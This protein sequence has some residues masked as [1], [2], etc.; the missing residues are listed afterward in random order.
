MSDTEVRLILLP[1]G[2]DSISV[3]F[4]VNSSEIE[5]EAAIV[6][7]A[8]V[9]PAIVEP[10]IAEHLTQ[11]DELLISS[12]CRE[13][14]EDVCEN[15]VELC[16]STLPGDIGAVEV[17]ITPLVD[18]LLDHAS[19]KADSRK[20]YTKSEF[21]LIGEDKALKAFPPA[22]D[23]SYPGFREFDLRVT[24]MERAATSDI[25]R[26][27]GLPDDD[28]PIQSL[29][30]MW[31]TNN[32]AGF[33]PGA[34]Q[35]A[36]Q[37][38][39]QLG[40]LPTRPP[41]GFPPQQN[42]PIRSRL[43]EDGN[44][45]ETNTPRDRRFGAPKLTDMA[46]GARGGAWAASSPPDKDG[47][48]GFLGRSPPDRLRDRDGQARVAAGP[49]VEH[50]MVQRG[51]D[52]VDARG[53]MDR[54]HGDRWGNDPKKPGDNWRQAIQDDR[55]REDRGGDRGDRGDRAPVKERWSV[56]RDKDAVEEVGG[57][58]G[59]R[60]AWEM[61]RQDNARHDNARQDNARQDNARQDRDIANGHGMRMDAHQDD[62]YGGDKGHSELRVHIPHTI[63]IPH[64]ITQM[65]TS[66][67]CHQQTV[68]IPHADGHGMRVDA[69]RDDG[70]DKRQGG[71]GGQGGRRDA[72]Q[73]MTAAEMETERLKMREEMAAAKA[74]QP[75]NSTT[76]IFGH[77]E[78]NLDDLIDHEFEAK[79]AHQRQTGPPPGMIPPVQG[80]KMSFQALAQAAASGHPGAMVFASDAAP[81]R[82]ALSNPTRCRIAN[83]TCVL[84]PVTARPLRRVV[85]VDAP[86]GDA[87]NMIALR[88]HLVLIPRH[89]S[90]PTLTAPSYPSRGT[91]L[92][93]GYTM[94]SRLIGVR[95]ESLDPEYPRGD[96]Y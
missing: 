43:I 2:E 55:N 41:P 1:V 60:R 86:L 63:T 58:D 64:A 95:S 47:G 25:L 77:E 44:M 82:E 67:T 88:P 19:E 91:Q 68:H 73:R 7:A 35:P 6:E 76:N 75:V 51:G 78:L 15:E 31:A 46:K 56:Q 54:G 4:A 27:L 94:R 10:A 28:D 74:K 22:L 23:L 14:V 70:G 62:G 29:K 3:E 36:Q 93:P 53:S 38:S 48:G 13:L 12:L 85:P 69:H 96:S 90:Q 20:L 61:G 50:E 71:Q 37:P 17:S 42:G 72:P 49:P 80:V 92:P 81:P 11:E 8:I 21:M 87:S 32:R 18:L 66:H 39:K 84:A 26:F 5:A 9:E 65:S 24:P 89:Y 52:R 30:P 40:G 79:P 59:G 34:R 57:N 45:P 33:A 16:I 83:A